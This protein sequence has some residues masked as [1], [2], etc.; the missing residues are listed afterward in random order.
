MNARNAWIRML[1]RDAWASVRL[2]K[3]FPCGLTLGSV[4][5]SRET[6]AVVAYAARKA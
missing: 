5:D 4:L 6:A 1:W 2:G 3:G